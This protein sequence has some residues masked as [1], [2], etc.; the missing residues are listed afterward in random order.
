MET[1][2]EGASEQKAERTKQIPVNSFV[3]KKIR[4]KN[5]LAVRKAALSFGS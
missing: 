2:P 5:K 3:Y 4:N 1:L